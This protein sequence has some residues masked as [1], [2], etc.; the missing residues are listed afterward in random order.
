MPHEEELAFCP[1]QLTRERVA[2]AAPTLLTHA[3][4]ENL[5]ELAV[6]SFRV[7]LPAVEDLLDPHPVGFGPGPGI[8]GAPMLQS[9][10][11][12]LGKDEGVLAGHAQEGRAGLAT[13]LVEAL[14]QQFP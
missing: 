11:H 9:V 13:E 12:G 7:F 3:H 14:G 8:D 6:W 10:H 1:M 2:P 4:R 5:A